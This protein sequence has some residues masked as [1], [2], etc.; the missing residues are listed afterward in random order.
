[1]RAD[2]TS[3]AL[4]IPVLARLRTSKSVRRAI[5]G[6]A[7]VSP[8]VLGLLVFTLG[9]M[10]ASAYF[11][12]TKY[13]LINPPRWTGFDNYVKMFTRD[14]LFGVS[15]YNTAYYSFFAVLFQ[16]LVALIQALI[17]NMKVK[18]VNIYRT[19]FY[20]PSVTPT[21]A[22]VILWTYILNKNYGLINSGLWLIGIPPVDW[23]YNPRIVKLSLVLM[24]LW[25]VGARMV[26]FLAALQQVP[27]EL[28]ESAALD[29]AGWLRKTW[30]VTLPMIS[31]IIFFNVIMGIINT[32]QVFT[33]AFIATQGGPV[34]A[35]LFYILYLYRHAFESLHMGYASALAWVLFVIIMFFTAV[36]FGLSRYWVYYEAVR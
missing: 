24:T 36:Q 30:N 13:D 35:T 22:M 11:S 6:W 23:L 29:G 26:V 21:V 15:L 20:L 14:K 10:V 3:S 9:P 28:Y 16:T 8:G 27:E 33:A 34:N 2:P 19:L 31:P 17:L 5:E 18:G 1:M 12:L 4:R 32:F 7:F 25:R